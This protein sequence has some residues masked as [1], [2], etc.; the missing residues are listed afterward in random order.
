MKTKILL[1]KEPCQKNKKIFNH[2]HYSINIINFVDDTT[3]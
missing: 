2:L 1:M 3:S